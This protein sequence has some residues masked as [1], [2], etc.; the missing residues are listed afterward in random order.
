MAGA[1]RAVAGAHP[2]AYSTP[3]IVSPGQFPVTHQVLVLHAVE[4]AFPG[5]TT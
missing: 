5:P 2:R 3:D 1:A 4:V